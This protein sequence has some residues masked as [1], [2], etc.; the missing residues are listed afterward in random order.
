MAWTTV[1]SV[2]SGLVQSSP[3]T[4][5]SAAN[6]THFAGCPAIA[7]AGIELLVVTNRVFTAMPH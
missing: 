1:C 3:K 2:Y 6:P 5:P 7:A 4:K